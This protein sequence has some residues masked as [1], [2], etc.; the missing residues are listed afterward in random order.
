MTDRKKLGI[1]RKA[2][3]KVGKRIMWTFSKKINRLFLHAAWKSVILTFSRLTDNPNEATRI[4]YE[5][6][7]GAGDSLMYTWLDKAKMLYS[8]NVEDMKVIVESAWHAF[9]G[10]SPDRIKY[11]KA[12]DGHEVE[13][14]VWQFDK[15]WICAEV[16]EDGEFNHLDFKNNEFG[17]GSCASGIFEQAL[18]QVVEYVQIP[19]KVVIRETKCF[20]RGDSCQE[21]TAWFYPKEGS[22][23]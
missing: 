14:I 1:F 22:N 18:Q 3:G 13:R 8:Q 9:L 19:Y 16:M 6:G 20:M 15:C 7:K 4:W 11:F 2:L 10:N 12:G 17:Y 5:L 23:E 21:F